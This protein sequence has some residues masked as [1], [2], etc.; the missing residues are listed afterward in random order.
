MYVLD[1]RNHGHSPHAPQM[2]YDLMSRDTVSFFRR[3][4]LERSV[5]IGHS[6]GGKTVMNVALE[7]P[8]MVEKLVVVDVS[9]GTSAGKGDTEDLVQVL[10]QLDISVLRSR[11]E[12]DL[13][14]RE[15]IPVGTD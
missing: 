2:T 7:R 6:M 3:E 9:P 10:Q 12:A 14:L 5:L 4:G 11:R 8:E 1:A 15:Q 13:R